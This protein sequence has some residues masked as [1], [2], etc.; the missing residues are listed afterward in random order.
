VWKSKED[1]EIMAWFCGVGGACG[2]GH[3]LFLRD[4][5]DA[6]TSVIV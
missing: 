6:V 4:F 3:V 5:F 1:V 2:T